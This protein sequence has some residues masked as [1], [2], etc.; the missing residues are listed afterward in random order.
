MQL[1]PIKPESAGFDQRKMWWSRGWGADRH[2]EHDALAATHG[3][4]M[5]AGG[6]CVAFPIF[7]ENSE[8]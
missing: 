2:S 5:W 6:T 3:V 8:D 4:A 1:P 7:G